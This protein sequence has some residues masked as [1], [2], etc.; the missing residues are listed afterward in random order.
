MG[1]LGKLKKV[2]KESEPGAAI[3]KAP[4]GNLIRAPPA[5]EHCIAVNCELYA[6]A[7]TV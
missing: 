5:P 3:R 4:G 7:G 6:V 2:R 1:K